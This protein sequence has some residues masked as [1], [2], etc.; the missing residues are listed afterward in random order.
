M[1]P[2]IAT[3]AARISGHG[4][5][6]TSTAS[7]RSQSC[8]AKY[9]IVHT[10]IVAGVNYTAY[11]SARR[12][13]GALLACADRTSSTMRAYWLCAASAV[14]RILNARKPLSELLITAEPDFTGTGIASPVSDD[15]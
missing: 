15:V 7:V 2:M 5:A 8:V 9:T 4:V 11:L 13:I 3:G 10:T 12:W 14:A 6:T 1:P